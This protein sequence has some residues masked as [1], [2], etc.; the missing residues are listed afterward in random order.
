MANLQTRKPNLWIMVGLP[1][2]GK[3]TWCKK[4]VAAAATSGV[5]AVHVSRDVI[6]Y[7][8]VDENEPYFAKEHLVYSEF[9]KQIKEAIAAGN[10]VYA[11]A[12]HLNWSSRR[13]L[14]KALGDETLNKANVGTIYFNTPIQICLDRNRNRPGRANVPEGVIMS[15]KG[16]M[17]MPGSDPYMYFNNVTIDEA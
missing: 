10:D 6:R 1:G 2:S 8:I 14:L 3:T 17:T 13:K 7:S 15:M 9:V 12:T 16:G 5:K 11:D 4:K